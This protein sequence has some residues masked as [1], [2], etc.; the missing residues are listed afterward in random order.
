MRMKLIDLSYLRYLINPCMLNILYLPFTQNSD[1]HFHMWK[2]MLIVP[3]LPESLEQRLRASLQ[4]G[5]CILVTP[6]S[7]DA[8]DPKCDMNRLNGQNGMVF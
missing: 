8:E 7:L 1:P 6:S 3:R 4:T 5:N 2:A